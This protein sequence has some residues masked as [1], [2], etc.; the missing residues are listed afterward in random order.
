MQGACWCHLQARGAY[1]QPSD[2]LL[3]LAQLKHDHRRI[4]FGK[5]NTEITSTT[6]GT[7]LQ[8]DHQALPYM[9][10]LEHAPCCTGTEAYILWNR[11]KGYMHTSKN[12]HGFLKM[13]VV[14][15]LSDLLSMPE[16]RPLCTAHFNVPC[17]RWCNF[18]LISERPGEL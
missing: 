4:T 11:G 8:K 13:H 1:S 9:R 14:D 16:V 15:G 3:G 17:L 5:G 18:T 2:L 10:T 7:K 6:Y 12:R